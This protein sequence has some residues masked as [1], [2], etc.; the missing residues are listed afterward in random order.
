M[1]HIALTLLSLTLAACA[2]TVAP[3][4]TGGTAVPPAG[5]Y[6]TGLDNTCDGERFA[7]LIGQSATA[8]E[9]VLFLGQVR[10]IRPGD[11]TTQDYRPER[12][13]IRIDAAERV[14]SISCG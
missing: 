8:L 12:L 6:P 4:N 11:L 13:N 9:R 3:P 1:R 7:P 2:G 5:S 10:I 14:Q